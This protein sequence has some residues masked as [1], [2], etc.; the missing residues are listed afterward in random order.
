MIALGS[1]LGFVACVVLL[2]YVGHLAE[3]WIARRFPVGRA[4]HRRG[5]S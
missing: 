4:A 2:S 1:A 3:T 5:E